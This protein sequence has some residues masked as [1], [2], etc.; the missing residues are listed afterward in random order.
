[1]KA[2]ALALLLA[3]G[4]LG[5]TQGAAHAAETDIAK[6][7][8][9]CTACHGAKGLS[10]NPLW[11]NL[12]GQNE[13]YLRTQLLAFRDGRR[14]DPLM[15]A[16]AKDL[17]DDQIDALAAHY[18]KLSPPRA[19]EVHKNSVNKNAP[20]LEATSRPLVFCV[21]C[22]GGD[23]NSPND[24]WPNLAGQKQTYMEKQIKAYHAGDR[25]D[26]MMA[27]WGKMVDEKQMADIL[28]Y[29]SRQG[30]K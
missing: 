10:V 18:G 28:G 20:H 22:H 30:R 21:R 2:T 24:I 11:P 25:K 29:F 27:M 14:K 9:T 19:A 16:T 7:L 6:Q 8:I 17:S 26:D 1:M 15:S 12:A 5:T 4:L 3:C 23:G 13:E